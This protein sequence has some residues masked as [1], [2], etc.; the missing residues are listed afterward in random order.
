MKTPRK[1]P[2]DQINAT[3]LPRDRTLICQDAQTELQASI[4][5]SGLRIPIE[6]HQTETGLA[7]ISGY[8]RLLAFQTLHEATQNEKYA[9]IA[10]IIRDPM[11]KQTALAAMVEENEVRQN[12]SPWERARIAVTTT[13][14]ALFDTIDAAIAKLYPQISRQKRAKL[15]AVT[16]V[17]EALSGH[18]IDPELLTENQLM[19][20]AQALRLNWAEIIITTIGEQND[21]TCADQWHR[22]LPVLQEVE[23]R[24]TQNQTTNPNHP[25]RLSRPKKG[26]SIRRE[27]TQNG[28]ILHI[29]GRQ[30]NDML[31]TS[32]LED[33]ERMMGPA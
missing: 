26:V 20:L 33:I 27:R 15:R 28:Y 19:R 4:A 32:V 24:F 18:L 16:E 10:A 1:I 9:Q 7:L 2:L 30:A 5:R 8:R 3:D 14:Q 6:V 17:I 23:A 21:K 22:L 11:D 25:R 29:T 12:L 31:V 13:N